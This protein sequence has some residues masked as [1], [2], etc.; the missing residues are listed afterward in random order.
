MEI[1]EHEP[2][3]LPALRN[4]YLESRVDSFPWLDTEKFALEDFDRDTLGEQ[5]WVVEVS[6]TIAGFISIWEPEHF[7]HH[8]YVG[9]AYRGLGLGTALIHQAQLLYG[10][11]SLKCM[12]PNQKALEF[13]QAKGFEIRDQVEDADGGYYLMTCPAPPLD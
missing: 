10:E 9:R 4:L 1:K 13:Y 5:I 3:H 6:G 12:V 11:L 8:L 2:H 7:I